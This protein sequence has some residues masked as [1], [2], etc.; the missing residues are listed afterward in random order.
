MKPRHYAII[1][2]ETTGLRAPRDK[3]TEI[4]ILLHDGTRVLNEWSTL[5]NPG[6]LLP[7]HISELTGITNEMLAKAPRFYEV[8]REIVERTEG[9]VFVAHNVRF[10]Y[11]FV[12][13][14]F[15]R[16]GYTYSRRQLCTVHL[17][18]RAFPGLPS[19][20]LDSLIHHLDIP[21]ENRHRALGDARATALLFG[22]IL[23]RQAGAAAAKKFIDLGLRESKL[24]PGL[25]MEQIEALPEACGVYYFH[26]SLGDVVYVGK[27]KN[28]RKRVVEHF[29][30]VGSKGGRMQRHVRDITYEL[31]GSE[32]VALLLESDEIKR[33]RP[34]LN[35]AQR[36][37]RFPWGLVR[38]RDER[39]Y[40]HLD[41]EKLSS[42]P[43]QEERADFCVLSEYPKAQGAR[44]RL[45]DA[46]RAF[47]LCMHLAHLEQGSGPCFEYHLGRCRGACVG[48]EQPQAYNDRVR[49]AE[50]CLRTVFER[51]FVVLDKGRTP[52]E[53]AV[54]L[55][56]GGHYVGFAFADS[57][58]LPS[59]VAGLC[60]LVQPRR[61]TPEANRI[62][63][64]FL[65]EAPA[66]ARVIHLD[67]GRA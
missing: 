36:V 25:G 52:E 38:W 57:A 4:A 21:V 49:E 6:V 9:A 29:A 8:A 39:G 15:R 2:I 14:E 35:R 59:D 67:G 51:D 23:D 58:E 17:A 46:V 22:H 56:R 63:Q 16:L 7:C 43:Y 64:R 27:S 11:A 31:T 1:D 26:D 18:R 40:L 30:H 19:Y 47:E 24:P 34:R 28:I 33:L 44:R 42:Q 32:L 13:E 60:E 50:M 20:S 48:L 10:D 45:K 62:I 53:C 5:I 55:V 61:T 54:V 41:V 65:A 12:R 3:I 66:S 37:R